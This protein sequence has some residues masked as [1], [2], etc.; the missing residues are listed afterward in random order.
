MTWR[1]GEIYWAPR[2]R[3]RDVRRLYE[4]DAR[5]IYD[6]ELIDE[7][8]WALY[9]RCKSFIAAVEAL[10]GRVTCPRC[11]EVILRNS[12]PEE[13]LHCSACGWEMAWRTY[14]KSFQH[15]QLS[16][17]EPVV[18]FFRVPSPFPPGQVP[19]RKWC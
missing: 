5:G 16:G 18:R 19:V 8:G 14:H 6:E 15:K 13:I 3:Q 2:V 11:G 1:I 7:V 4:T 17:A 9:M 10:H 12:K